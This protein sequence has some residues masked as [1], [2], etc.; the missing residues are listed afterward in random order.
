MTSLMMERHPW[1]INIFFPLFFLE[2]FRFFKL[3]WLIFNFFLLV[4]TIPR[5]LPS[6]S[7]ST[8]YTA[9][10]KL[11]ICPR[12]TFFFQKFLL[13]VAKAWSQTLLKPQ[14]S[15]SKLRFLKSR[16]LFFS[17]KDFFFLRSVKVQVQT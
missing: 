1:K 4:I 6:K 9:L 3:F 11:S 7:P 2:I 15:S 13:R 10:Q 16:V 5:Q 12:L 14:T 17:S 8:T